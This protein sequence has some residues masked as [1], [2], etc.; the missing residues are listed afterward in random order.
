MRLTNTIRKKIWLCVNVA[1]IGFIVATGFAL[2][3]NHQIKIHL[4]H[5]R[6]LDFDLA[7]RSNELLNLFIRQK[8]FY[9][10]SFLFGSQD[11]ANKGNSLCK[12]IKSKINSITQLK[13]SFHSLPPDRI[14]TLI[15]LENMYCDYIEHASKLYPL[16][17]Q[18][19]DPG[20]HIEALQQLAAAQNEIH[21]NLEYFSKFYRLHFS[22][23][24]TYLMDMTKRNSGFLTVFFLTL[25][26]VMLGV[27]NL[28]AK[29]TLIIPLAHIKDAVRAFGHGQRS[30]PE[31]EVMD[32]DDDIGELGT[33]IITMT[34]DLVSTTVSKAYVDSILRNMNDSLIVTSRDF[35]IR[36]VN[37]ST[38]ELLGYGKEE[39]IGR[40]I[41]NVLKDFLCGEMKDEAFDNDEEL[42]LHLCSNAEK[43]FVT[44]DGRNIPILLSISWL[45][46][47]ENETHGL[48]YVAKDITDRKKAEQKLQQ[49]ALYD[50]LTGLPNRM[51]FTDRLEQTLKQAHR[52]GH[53]AGLMFLDLDRFKDINDTLGHDS[54][55]ALLKKAANWLRGCVRESDTVARLGGDEFAIILDKLTEPEDAVNTAERILSAFTRP[56]IYKGN[57]IYSSPSIGIAFYPRDAGNTEALLK[58]ADIAMYRVKQNGG[59]GYTFFS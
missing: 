19:E 55:D 35:H 39:L 57:E 52:E 11:S 44:R 42:S 4:T 37:R 15:G 56:V 49:L 27:V 8:N 3:S 18:G 43:T 34:K 58:N 7:I 51:T 48:V 13:R 10:D 1:L 21:N 22:N 26:V 25:L 29:R 14:E 46:D 24:V 36:S 33:A 16:L 28:A 41:N 2:Y 59:N 30:F 45:K 53:Q 20:K 12:E 40:H 32:A 9:K 17:A 31:L 38:L 54:G 23:N 50:F 5:I 6:D 47:E